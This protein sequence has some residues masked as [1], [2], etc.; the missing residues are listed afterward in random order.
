MRMQRLKTARARENRRKIFEAAINLFETHGFDQVTMDEIAKAAGVARSSVF[1]H[2]PSKMDILA[3]FFAHFT[4]TVIEAA[5]QTKRRTFS[6]RLNAL[7]E[8]AG[9]IAKKH[10]RVLSAIASLAV[11]HGPLAATE[12]EADQQLM[13]YLTT[14]VERAQAAEEIRDDVKAVFLAN[15]ILALMTATLHDW[16]NGAFTRELGAELS[17]R[18]DILMSGAAA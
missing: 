1:N 8:A 17:A 2:Y 5:R 9:A 13:D 16:V 11:G 18:F 7:F 14:L 4:A 10:R 12:S 15:L 6:G 3:E